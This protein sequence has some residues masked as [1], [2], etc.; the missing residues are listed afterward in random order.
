MRLAIAAAV[1][2]V[3]GGGCRSETTDLPMPKTGGFGSA[4]YPVQFMR[5][6]IAPVLRACDV[7]SPESAT[8]LMEI[9]K[10]GRVV[11]ASFPQP[12]SVAV[13]KCLGEALALWRLEPARDCE[14]APL[15]SRWEVPYR[16]VF[17]LS[18]CLP[19]EVAR[20]V[21]KRVAVTPTRGRTSGCS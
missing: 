19:V 8:V 14:G 7:G 15:A 4:C 11:R 17:G 3:L 16:R 1:L 6:P 21:A 2:V 10:E 12:P 9:S 18:P 5:P 20:P 13:S